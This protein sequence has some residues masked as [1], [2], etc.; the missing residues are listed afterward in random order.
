M[1]QNQI[2][3]RD[4]PNASQSGFRAHHSTALQCR[5]LTDHVTLN[6]NNKI[7]TAAVFLNIEKAFDIT[8][9]SG[10]LYKLCKLEF[11]TSFI[12]LIDPFPSQKNQSFGGRR[13]VNARCNASRDATKFGLVPYSFQYV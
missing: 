4:L 9:H 10:L 5:K 2:D 11:S 3:E 12:K 8:W 7:F 6:F 1:L 13:N